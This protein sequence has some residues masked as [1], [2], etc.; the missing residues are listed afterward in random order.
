MVGKK[1]SVVERFSDVQ[2][3]IELRLCGKG[4][5]VGRHREVT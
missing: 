1:K 2:S 3:N 4:K 5:V